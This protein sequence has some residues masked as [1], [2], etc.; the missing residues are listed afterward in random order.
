ML[1]FINDYEGDLTKLL[2][3]FN[4]LDMI[5]DGQ[6]NEFLDVL[7]YLTDNIHEINNNPDVYRSLINT[8]LS[9]PLGVF[10]FFISHGDVRWIAIYARCRHINLMV[11]S[12]TLPK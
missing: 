4:S 8:W 10:K 11:N 3:Q 1:P 5:N 6:V 7:N 2:E 12:I 9:T